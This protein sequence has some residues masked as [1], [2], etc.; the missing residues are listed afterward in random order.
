MN[1]ALAE[2]AKKYRTLLA[3]RAQK[4]RDGSEPAREAFRAL[5]RQFPGALRE[6]EVLS[7]E[8]LEQRA[9]EL[10]ACARGECEATLWMLAIESFHRW[11]RVALRVKARAKAHSHEM[12]SDKSL[13]PEDAVFVRKLLDRGTN[14]LR[15]VVIERVAVDLNVEPSVVAHIV[16]QREHTNTRSTVERPQRSKKLR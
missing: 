6:L 8:T 3:W 12:S 2:L 5:A 10:E 7:T 1:E 9:I 13:A 14:R 11:M 15:P 4:Q 16:L